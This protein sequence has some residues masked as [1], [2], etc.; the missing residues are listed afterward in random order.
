LFTAPRPSVVDDACR[1]VVL[2]L[3]TLLV[4]LLMSPLMAGCL[5]AAVPTRQAC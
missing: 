4:P 1:P 2:A 5:A 3:R